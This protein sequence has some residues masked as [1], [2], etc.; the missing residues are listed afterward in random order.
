MEPQQGHAPFGAVL[1]EERALTG[2]VQPR[3]PALIA[4][5]PCSNEP[6]AAQPVPD[7]GPAPE[8]ARAT[9]LPAPRPS[10]GRVSPSTGAGAFS[11]PRFQ[12]KSRLPMHHLRPLQGRPAHP[13]GAASSEAVLL[14]VRGVNCISFVERFCSTLEPHSFFDSYC[15]SSRLRIF[16]G[17]TWP[18]SWAFGRLVLSPAERRGHALTGCQTGQIPLPA[19]A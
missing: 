14:T 11:R 1:F 16:E 9:S 10:L 2:R 8:A 7:R 13:L 4:M 17:S 12:A 5:S 15:A 3:G 19:W 6:E 18:P